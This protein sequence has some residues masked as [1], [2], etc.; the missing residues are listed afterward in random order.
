M[1]E[2]DIPVFLIVYFSELSGAISCLGDNLFFAEKYACVGK[3]QAPGNLCLSLVGVRKWQGKHGDC[4]MDGRF[5]IVGDTL[6]C[7]SHFRGRAQSILI[8]V[9]ITGRILE[10]VMSSTML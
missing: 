1:R 10:R 8:S 5:R 3:I 7:S 2:T 9:L 4:S 6:Y